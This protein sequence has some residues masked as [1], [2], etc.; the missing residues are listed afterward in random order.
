LQKVK[1]GF[2]ATVVMPGD[3]NAAAHFVSRAAFTPGFTAEQSLAQ[4][5]TPIGGEGVAERL[6]KGLQQ[7]EQ[8]AALIAANDAALGVPAPKMFLRHAEATGPPP[9]WLTEVKTLYTGAMNEMYRGNTRARGGARPFI[10]YHAK[11]LEFALH[12]CTAI[13]SLRKSASDSEA[14]EQ[15]IEALYNALNAH[16]EV[17]RDASDRAA[18]ALL[19]EHGCRPLTKALDPR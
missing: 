5:V 16:A 13:E 18:I 15:A 14:R 1:S 6:W 11:R 12:F 9:A 8:A 7:V 3:L 17:A 4:L 10:L 19:N 2:V